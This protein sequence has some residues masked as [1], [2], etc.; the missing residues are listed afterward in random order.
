[1]PELSRLQ[2]DVAPA[3]SGARADAVVRDPRL[4]ARRRCV[5]AIA[6]ASQL[7]AV[8]LLVAQPLLAQTV[9]SR[10]N[11]I[12]AA[13][14]R[15]PRA[16]I[17]RAD[18][19]AAGAGLVLARQ[20]ENPTLGTSFTQSAPQTH[21]SLDIP[22]DAPWLRRPRIGVAQAELDA[23]T[24][25][26][27]YTNAALAYDVDTAYTRTLA[28]T[29][30]AQLSQRNTRDADSLLVLARVRQAAGDAS[31][32]DVQLAAV[33]AGQAANSASVDSLDALSAL[34][35]VQAAMGMSATS[36]TIVLAD[37]LALDATVAPRAAQS[38][39][40][41]TSPLLLDAAERDLLAADQS[42]LLERRRRIGAPSLSLGIEG[43]NPGGQGGGLPTIGL[44]IPI[45][46]FNQNG[47]AILA[48]QAN[49][50]RALALLAQTRLELNAAI[51]QAE[52][53]A[54]VARIRAE[55]SATLVAGADRI[56]T[57]SLLAY[58]EGASTLPNVLEAQRTA[59]ATLSQY[60]DDVA[61]ARN[62]AGLVRLL[63]L[64]A[65]PT[66]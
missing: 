7:V 63:S 33:F 47:A 9:V 13:V 65:V 32:L 38:A 42:V 52:R 60:I 57:L 26:F 66:P 56:A 27:V 40:G 45:P 5:A 6:I 49:Q 62:A 28:L 3:R 34:L 16:A 2:P 12:S 29:R 36:P 17:A 43:S 55:R 20:F 11:A 1:M 51:S 53:V 19:A 15:G 58:R 37:T 30:R 21:F 61:A 22:I 4:S 35:I 18:S 31:D 23:A 24:R 25:R 39:S 59:R 50:R 46:V 54:T 64:T 44:S 48:A 8:T 14:T 41:S 10:E